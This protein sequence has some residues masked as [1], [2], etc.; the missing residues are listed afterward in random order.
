MLPKPSFRVLTIVL[1]GS[2]VKARN[3][4]TRN[5]A[6]NAFNFNLDVRIIIARMLTPTRVDVNKTLIISTYVKNRYATNIAAVKPARSASSP[7]PIA[8]RV[9]FIPTEPKYTATM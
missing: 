8:C 7:H 4:D 6:M 2:V 9:F 5:K 1:T 3:R